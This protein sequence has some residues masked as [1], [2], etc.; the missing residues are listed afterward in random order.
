MKLKVC[1][2]TELGNIREIAALKP[3]YLGFIF[4]EKSPRF[5]AGKLDPTQLKN[6]AG[7]IKKTGV[8][9]N[10]SL[11]EIKEKIQEYDLA[12][13][14][15]HGDETPEFC[16]A[17]SRPGIKIIKAFSVNEIFDFTSVKP[18]KHC[19]DFF[20]FDTK[21]K[22]YGG[23]GIA[24]NWEILNNYDNSI[25]FFL[26]GGLDLDNIREIEKYR[27]LNIHSL[28]INSRFETSPGIKDIGMVKKL[29]KYLTD[30]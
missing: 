9:V 27:H 22:D 26:S 8:F 23:N 25:P 18:Y 28:D 4:Y 21:G 3:D 29:S 24:F 10:A 16:R 11:S 30:L 17:V 6:I 15:L 13:I 19:C 20:L 2:M 5:A 7:T 1:G 14:Q 12:L